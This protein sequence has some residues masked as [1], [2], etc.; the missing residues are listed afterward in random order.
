MQGQLR[1][2]QQQWTV[3]ILQ[4][5]EEANQPKGPIAEVPLSLKCAMWPPVCIAALQMGD[6]GDRITLDRQF[7]ELWNRC[8]ERSLNT[9]QPGAL[10][11]GRRSEDLFDEIPSKRI[12]GAAIPPVGLAYQ[13]WNDVV[14]ADR[15]EEV[16]E[17]P[18]FQVGRDMLKVVCRRSSGSSRSLSSGRSTMT[19][20]FRSTRSSVIR[21]L[22]RPRC[23]R[24]MLIRGTSTCRNRN[25]TR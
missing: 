6:T 12:A 4:R 18:E 1:F 25:R 14:V 21:S 2:L 16:G 13:L 17:R 15:R 22:C 10:L 20:P 23:S 8:G 9:R 7:L 11:P 3:T 24:V 5:P 19:S